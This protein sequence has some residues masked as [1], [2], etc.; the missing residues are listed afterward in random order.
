[1]DHVSSAKTVQ[2]ITSI[3]YLGPRRSVQGTCQF[4][5]PNA[6]EGGAVG[7]TVDPTGARV[8]EG[9]LENSDLSI[10]IDYEDFLACAAGKIDVLNLWTSGRI[11]IDGDVALALYFRDLV[12]HAIRGESSDGDFSFDKYFYQLEE[13]DGF[14]TKYGTETSSIV[15]T[16]EMSE[17]TN[18]QMLS[19]SRYRPTPIHVAMP[20]L[21]ALRIDHSAYTFMDI[22]CGKGRILL[23][24]SLFPFRRL[25]GVDLS[26]EL[27]RIAEK[28]FALFPH[29]KKRCHDFSTVC[30]DALAMDLP[31]ENLVFFLYEPFFSDV[32]SRFVLKVE[33][34]LR[35]NPRQISVISVGTTLN[36]HLENATWL[37]LEKTFDSPNRSSEWKSFIYSAK[38]AS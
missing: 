17:L 14:D 7:V 8:Y 37:E 21:Q 19:C 32:M 28:N 10:R 27:C 26:E 12:R 38:A 29:E 23:L 30:G 15:E 11:Q 35:E 22:G 13:Q 4:L 33:R 24:A 1:M 16:Y 25:V 34:S 5:F 36:G 18:P 9:V 6:P 2:M 31:Y 20:A 3:F